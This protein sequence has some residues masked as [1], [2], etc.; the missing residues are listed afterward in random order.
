MLKFLFLIFAI[1]N[2]IFAQKIEVS[3]LKSSVFKAD[4]FIGIDDYQNLYYTNGSTLVKSNATKTI[5]F[6][7]IQLGEITTVDI[8]NPLSITLFYKNF[9]TVVILDNTLNEITRI[10]FN[11]LDNYRNISFARTARDRKLWI[12]NQDQQRIELFNYRNNTIEVT[13]PSI[14]NKAIAMTSNFNFCWLATTENLLKFNS[15]GNLI[16]KQKI[17]LFDA[18]IEQNGSIIAKSKNSLFLQRKDQTEFIPLTI[19]AIDIKQ[20]YWTGE[21]IYIYQNDILSTYKIKTPKI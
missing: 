7:D 20:F 3:A 13:S 21:I 14:E 19:K 16:T 11:R 12:F 10:D 8:I 4:I 9:N 5:E 6:S 17:D 2:P 15:Y 1:S 18:I